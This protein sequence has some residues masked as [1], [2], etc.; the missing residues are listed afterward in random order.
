LFV[1]KNAFIKNVVIP[2]SLVN[3]G[4]AGTKEYY[5]G[6]NPNDL[7]S[8]IKGGLRGAGEIAIPGIGG[9]LASKLV[10]N[11]LAK[12]VVGG[13]AAL[14][15]SKAMDYIPEYLKKREMVKKYLEYQDIKNRY[16]DP[17]SM[18]YGGALE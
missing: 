15:S 13:T 2:A 12:A 14:M 18:Y 3:S 17:N 10:Q 11:P 7:L 1:E 8:T 6:E 9:Y 16:G 5:G 4:V